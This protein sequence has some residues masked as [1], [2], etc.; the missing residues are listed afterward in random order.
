MLRIKIP[1]GR[2]NADQLDAVADVTES[3]SQR[4]IAHVTTRQAI[5]VHFIPLAK[6]PSAMRR[7][8]QVNMTSREACGNTVRNMSACALSGVCPKEHVDVAAH[9]D[10]ATQHFLRNPLNQADAAQIQ[11]QLFR[12][13]VGLRAVAAARCGCGRGQERRPARFHGQGRWRFGA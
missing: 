9:I 11:D 4:G 5:Q 12:L 1:G 2:L 3:F 7:L 8:A 6:M 13:R 10:G